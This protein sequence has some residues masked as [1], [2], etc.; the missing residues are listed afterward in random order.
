MKAHLRLKKTT[1]TLLIVLLLISLVTA[2]NTLGSLV[3]C[4]G[5]DGHIAFESSFHKHCNDTSHTHVKDVV[6]SKHEVGSHIE[7]PH[8]KPCVDIPIPMNSVKDRFV[9]NQVKH[10]KLAVLSSCSPALTPGDT[11]V[12]TDTLKN[13]HAI[14]SPFIFLNTIILLA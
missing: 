9:S 7:N 13:L 11:F 5:E 8:C 10:N 14:T 3:L 6:L 2:G 4:I 1:K 12:S